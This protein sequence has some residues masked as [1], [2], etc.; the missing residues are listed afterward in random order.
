MA[1]LV[2]GLVMMGVINSAFSNVVS[3]FFGAKF[4]RSIEELLVS[5]TPHWVI[6]AG[7][8]L[9]GVLRGL[10][11]GI[12]VFVISALF[13]HP[14]IQHPFIVLLFGFLTATIFALGGFLNGLYARKFDDVSIFPVFVLTPLTYFGGVFYS[15]ALLPPFWQTVS[16]LNPILYIV[17]GF[18]YGFYSIADLPLAMSIGVLCA[19]III[20]VSLNLYLLKKGIGMR[21]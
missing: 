11:V 16:R 2:P 19:C 10:L 14:D 8:T 12:I 20:L 9:G 1:F 3:S 21:Q 4:Q 5:P 17:D 18:R 7:Y 13:V 6:L 15:I